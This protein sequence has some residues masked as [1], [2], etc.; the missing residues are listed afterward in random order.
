MESRFDSIYTFFIV[1]YH[2]RPFLLSSFYFIIIRHYRKYTLENFYTIES[3]LLKTSPRHFK[4]IL[5]KTPPDSSSSKTLRKSRNRHYKYLSTDPP[6]RHS[7]C[8]LGVWL[9]PLLEEEEER[10]AATRASKRARFSYSP[11]SSFQS[12]AHT[13]AEN[14]RDIFLVSARPIDRFERR[15]S[16]WGHLLGL[17]RE[18]IFIQGSLSQPRSL[19]DQPDRKAVGHRPRDTIYRRCDSCPFSLYFLFKK[20]FWGKIER[21]IFSF[22]SIF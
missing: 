4:M 8:K 12:H 21:E 2:Q 7:K 3:R 9:L 19:S 18:I 6:R 10:A 15:S 22:F 5:R 11:L 17:D 14:K 13:Q 16:W 1:H 20:S